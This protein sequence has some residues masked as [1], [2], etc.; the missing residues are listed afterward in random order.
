[1]RTRSATSWKWSLTLPE[2]YEFVCR[3]AYWLTHPDEVYTDV[4]DDYTVEW[5]VWRDDPHTDGDGV[6]G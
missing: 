3:P 6:A 5:G 1:M 4:Y 2:E